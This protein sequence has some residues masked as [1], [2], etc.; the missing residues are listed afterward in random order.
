MV[1]Y[2]EMKLVVSGN[3]MGLV[4]KPSQHN[5]QTNSDLGLLTWI[6]ELA[7]RSTWVDIPCNQ[8]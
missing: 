6:G 1:C 3:L 8:G 4:P 2:L 7:V 5:R